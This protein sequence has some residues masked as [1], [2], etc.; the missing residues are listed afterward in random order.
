[1]NEYI[2][3]MAEN[4][5]LMLQHGAHPRYNESYEIWTE[6][7]VQTPLG[8]E[9]VRALPEV[10]EMMGK[11]VNDQSMNEML[12]EQAL[13]VH[14]ATQWAAEGL[15]VFEVTAGLGAALMLT[16]PTKKFELRLPF[17]TFM[18]A[19]PEGIIP[20]YNPKLQ[21]IHWAQRIFVHHY[22]SRQ[23]NSQML[24]WAA[25]TAMG[26]TE[27]GGGITAWN[28]QPMSHLEELDNEDYLMHSAESIINDAKLISDNDILTHK[29]GLRLIRNFCSWLQ[30]TG[31]LGKHQPTNHKAVKAARR[32]VNERGQPVFPVWI[33]GHEVKL[34][35]ELREAATDA[36]LAKT[37]KPRKGWHVRVAHVV[38]GHMK[39]QAFGAGHAERKTIWV[40][41][42]WRNLE[43]EVAWAHIY[44]PPA[45]RK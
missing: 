21:T 12:T 17:N 32:S 45:E 18:L 29:A 4:G 37:S 34:P 1:M 42:Y 38:R 6:K 5:I 35:R 9:F 22:H 2:R 10:I 25:S 19:L 13:N 39:H 30:S 43:A 41:P 24:Y 26:I 16:E 28:R 31:G 40:Q 23:Y 44:E 14:M 11:P 3:N 7:F 36:V 15:N 20:V 27:I 33:M 8:A